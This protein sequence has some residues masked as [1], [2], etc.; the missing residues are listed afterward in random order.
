MGG[1]VQG[2]GGWLRSIQMT[3]DATPKNVEWLFNRLYTESRNIMAPTGTRP[4]FVLLTKN[5]FEREAIEAMLWAYVVANYGVMQTRVEAQM[6]SK[7]SSLFFLPEVNAGIL[8][9]DLEDGE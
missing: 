7:T 3:I 1:M 4:T 6:S 2:K 5:K 8:L 9:M